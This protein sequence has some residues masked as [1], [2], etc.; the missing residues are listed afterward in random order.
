MVLQYSFGTTLPA[1]LGEGLFTS[2]LCGG[3]ILPTSFVVATGTI[4]ET[5]T[6]C[7]FCENTLQSSHVGPKVGDHKQLEAIVLEHFIRK[8]LGVEEE[9]LGDASEIFPDDLDGTRYKRLLTSVKLCEGCIFHFAKN[10]ET[11]LKDQ[12]DYIGKM[13]GM[14]DYSEVLQDPWLDLKRLAYT[15]MTI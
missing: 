12:L 7:A 1:D 5:K 3:G 2:P 14:R 15:S 4:I 8:I 13:S 6:T 10:E 9:S 11:L